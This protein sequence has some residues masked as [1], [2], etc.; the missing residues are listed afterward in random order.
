MLKYKVKLYYFTASKTKQSSGI[1]NDFYF[2][3][4]ECA[5][6]Q[7]IHKVDKCHVCEGDNRCNS[8]DADQPESRVDS[9]GTCT[10]PF[11]DSW[12]SK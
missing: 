11:D 8:C 10:L 4:G 7:T 2:S 5:D 1:L 6:D 12:N 9:C 3:C